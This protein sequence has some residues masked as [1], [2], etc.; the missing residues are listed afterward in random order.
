MLA[1]IAFSC[2]N[3]QSLDISMANSAV[4]RI[5]GYAEDSHY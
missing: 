4:N 5:T 3:L 2:P 1:C